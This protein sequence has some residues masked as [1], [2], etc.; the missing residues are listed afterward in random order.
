MSHRVRNTSLYVFE[1]NYKSLGEGEGSHLYF[2]A[3]N[4]FDGNAKRVKFTVNFYA[5]V[6]IASKKQFVYVRCQH[7]FL[8]ICGFFC[9]MAKL[10]SQSEKVICVLMVV[11]NSNVSSVAR[12]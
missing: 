9:H 10:N 7:T 12:R 1:Y 11:R 5:S 4:I 2:S 3:A 8:A 6:I